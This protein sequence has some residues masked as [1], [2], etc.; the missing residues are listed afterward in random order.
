MSD[1]YEEAIENLKAWYQPTTKQP[2]RN[3][4]I[5]SFAIIHELIRAQAERENPK[6]LTLEELREMD[7]EPV[8]CDWISGWGIVHIDCESILEFTYCDGSQNTYEEIAH[9]GI[10][11]LAY[12]RPPKEDKA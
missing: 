3:N 5:T 6:A 10:T 4:A 7:E 8:W 2:E 9:C 12:A 1:K 11:P